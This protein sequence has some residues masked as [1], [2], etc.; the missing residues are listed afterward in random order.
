MTERNPLSL[1]E[2]LM[3][4]ALRDEEGTIE[5]GS[6]YQYAIGGAVLAELLMRDR[7]HLD[8]SRKK[9]VHLVN[10]KLLGDPLLDDCL[11]KV[12]DSRK[13]LAAQTWVTKFAGVK[14]LKHRLAM[15]L[16]D[17]GILKADEDKVLSSGYARRSSARPTTSIPVRWSWFPWPIAQRFSPWFLTR[18]TS[19]SAR[20]ESSA[21]SRVMPWGRPPRRLSKPSRQRSLSPASCR[22]SSRARRA[23][24]AHRQCTKCARP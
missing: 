19:K 5:M 11:S 1:P 2:E 12:Q 23:R 10:A 8:T 16:C 7:L 6:M 18:K 14:N 9:T 4:L 13:Q 22:S 21:S 24:V 17:R 20:T 3:L 15:R